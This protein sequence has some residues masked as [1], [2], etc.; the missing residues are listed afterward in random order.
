MMIRFI[1]LPVLLAALASL[2][3]PA[4]EVGAAAE[5]PAI[6][7]AEIIS[8]IRYLASDALEGREAGTP[9]SEKAARYVARMFE[10]AGLRPAGDDGTYFQ[11][12]PIPPRAAMGETNF[13]LLSVKG[14]T[15][16]LRPGVDYSPLGVTE[17]GLRAGEIIFA[18][19]GIS[20]PELGYDNYGGLDTRGKIVLA[21]RYAPPGLD[22]R[23]RYREYSSLRHK[24]AT[25]MDKGARAVIFTTPASRS[26][27]EDL[28]SAALDV[29]PAVRGMQAIIVRR[30]VAE[31]IL[32][33]SGRSLG[34]MEKALAGGVGSPLPLPGAR[35]E[36]RTELL[37]SG[38]GASN[39]LGYIEGRDPA[40]RGEVIVVGAHY[41]HLGMRASGG[42]ET[43]DY[44]YN[45]ADDNASGVAGL[46][47]LAEYFASKSERPRRSLVFAAFSGEEKGLLGSSY[48]V[49]NRKHAPGRIIAM[50]NLDMIGRLGGNGITVF[51]WTSSPA[52][53]PVIDAARSSAGLAVEYGGRAPGPSDQHAFLMSGIP[54]VQLS[55]GI[56]GDYHTP[57]DEWPRINPE[58]TAAVIR[59]AAELVGYLANA[60]EAG[61]FSREAFPG[62]GM[63]GAG[64]YI[65]ALPDYSGGG[66]VRLS[67]D[68]GV[69]LLGVVEHSPAERA[70]LRA[71]DRVVK[72]S[73][74]EIGGVEDYIGGVKEASPGEPI[75]VTVVRQGVPASVSLVPE[76]R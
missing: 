46:M 40:V 47:E 52:W 33:A 42:A 56:H 43:A 70:G 72:L 32:S 54:A 14:R 9:G 60:G 22:R 4:E 53:R 31:E 20:A 21:L 68:K 38:G 2:P 73:G 45:G 55:T 63:S 34:E 16:G 18:G 65:G 17:D 27:E 36:I 64:V 25:A 30:D 8:H 10:K 69:K 6:T 67:D 59:A 41:D 71:G 11:T 3:S 12:F 61:E 58:G 19:Y 13:F 39:V 50:V 51:G 1:A 5:D 24:I 35:A 49:S 28:A 48:Y 26:E 57:F 7:S 66:G 37:R 23:G 75:Q 74:R 76:R 44:I 29:P 15:E 62:E